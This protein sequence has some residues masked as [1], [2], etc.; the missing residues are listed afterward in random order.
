[1]EV[2]RRRVGKDG[3]VYEPK[4][5]EIN[6]LPRGSL[7][8]GPGYS[9]LALWNV[10]PQA[11]VVEIRMPWILLGFVGPHQMRVLQAKEDGTNGSVVSPG[12]GL[13]VVLSSATGAPLC[14]WPGLADQTV[15]TSAAGRYTWKEWTVETDQVPH[16]MTSR[17][18]A[19]CRRCSTRSTGRRRSPRPR[20]PPDPVPDLAPALAPP[21]EEAPP[22]PPP[23]APPTTVPA[24]PAD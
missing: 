4:F 1:M 12:V 24:V 3:A 8:Q 21:V 13:S 18:T 14:A 2:N 11:G 19:P 10:S 17:C 15:T 16:A 5:W 23:A 6:P 22:P 20:R 9:D 7:V